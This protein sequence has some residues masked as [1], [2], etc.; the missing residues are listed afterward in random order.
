L[1]E[2]GGGKPLKGVSGTTITWRLK[3][4]MDTPV[5]IGD[6]VLAVRYVPDDGGTF[7]VDVV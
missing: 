7:K 4:V 3:G 6:Q 5:Q 2:A 1:E